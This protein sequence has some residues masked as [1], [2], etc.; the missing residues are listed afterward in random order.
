VAVDHDKPGGG[1]PHVEEIDGPGPTRPGLQEARWSTLESPLPEDDVRERIRRA[2]APRQPFAYG[3]VI[4]GSER[5]QG[6]LIRFRSGAR[7]LV[8]EVA[9]AAWEGGT[10]VHVALP[11]EQKRKDLD[12]L[13]DWLGRVLA[14]RRTA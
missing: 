7:I 11:V 13:V 14:E 4:S 5:R 2:L 6:F 3:K 12:I 1:Y 9:L 10:Q 8:G